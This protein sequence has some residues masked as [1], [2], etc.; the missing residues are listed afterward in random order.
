MVFLIERPHAG[1]DEDGL[2]NARLIH[3]DWLEPALQRRIPLDV[4]A[5]LVQRCGANRLELSTRKRWLQD[6]RGVHRALGRACPDERVQLVDEEDAAGL[7]DLADD[8]LEPLLELATILGARYQRTDIERDQPLVLQLLWYIARDDSL[9]QSLDNR[10]LANPGLPDQRRIVLRPPGEN[11][12]HPVDF[13]SPSDQRAEPA[14]SRSLGQIDT[15]GI[16]IGGLGLLLAL[17]VGRTLADDLHY[18]GAHLFQIDAQTLQHAGGN[19]LT[20]PHQTKQEMLGTDVMVIEAPRL[21]DRELDNLLGSRG[22]SD[23]AHD[24]GLTTANNELDSRTNLRQLHA[25]VAQHAGGDPITFANETQQKMLCTN[26]VVVE[27]LSLFLRQR[28]HLPGALC[29]LV[30]LI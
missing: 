14:R 29:E 26:V 21:I 2:V 6:V 12:H 11:L 23:F 24:H 13:G 3:L 4:L 17:A 16:H 30:E 25:H 7:L 18:L 15:Q 28:Q 10:G 22:K 8:L 20:F 1:E 27:T 19:S 5:I 9:R